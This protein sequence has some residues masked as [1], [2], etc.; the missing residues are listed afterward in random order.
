MEFDDSLDVGSLGE[1]TFDQW[2]RSAKL[3]SIPSEHDDKNGWDFL[4]EFPY[5]KTDLPDD[6]RPKPFECKVQVKS[7]LGERGAWDIKL[8]VL[9]RLIDYT[10]P[11]F[12]L[13]YEFSKF[14]PH[15]LQ[16]AYLVHIDENLIYRVLKKIRENSGKPSPRKLHKIDLS[17]S[18]HKNKIKEPSGLALRDA[19][20]KHIPKGI[21]SYQREK[22]AATRRVGYENGK[23]LEGS[24]SAYP[25]E[26]EQYCLDLVL[27]KDSSLPIT[28]HITKDKRFND[29]DASYI[30][31]QSTGGKL[32]ITSPL[33]TIAIGRLDF[34]KNPFSPAASFNTEMIKAPAITLKTDVIYLKTALFTVE[35]NIPFSEMP[36]NLSEKKI[37]TLTSH[38]K[39]HYTL[40][41]KAT[42]YEC[43]QW[44]KLHDREFR[45]QYKK[46]EFHSESFDAPVEA[47]ITSLPDVEDDYQHLVKAMHRITLEFELDTSIQLYIG[48][49]LKNREN[50]IALASIFDCDKESI[51]LADNEENKDYPDEI[52]SINPFFL[53]IGD[54]VVGSI[55]KIEASNIEGTY[56]TSNVEILDKYSFSN[57]PSTHDVINNLVAKHRESERKKLESMLPSDTEF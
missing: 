2:C 55:V 25:E 27:G 36:D 32:Q 48:E 40:E 10:S 38:I 50:F 5:V 23:G 45:K 33:T 17:I 8:S 9:K 53:S 18:Y 12:I 35:V 14:E 41:N 3:T 34:K 28:S 56:H 44:L 26:I 22:V 42:L 7:T 31:H 51:T 13:F 52:C 57:S 4:V 11:A 49:L 47:N 46:V 43:L 19:I 1:S 29:E 20:I 54:F 37:S 39:F 15:N 16:N 21:E 6:L 24:F 30:L